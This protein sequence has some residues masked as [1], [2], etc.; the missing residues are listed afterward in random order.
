M[1]FGVIVV[2]IIFI[3]LIFY[4]TN[5]SNKS[6]QNQKTEP[7]RFTV[8]SLKEVAQNNQKKHHEKFEN[9]IEEAF[10]KHITQ[11]LKDTPNELKNTPVVT[12]LIMDSLTS[13][14]QNLID[15]LSAKSE[16][17]NAMSQ[18]K[19]ES[20]VDTAQKKVFREYFQYS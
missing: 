4:N 20:I 12:T 18:T 17:K 9:T 2:A 1:S 10:R 11:C 3:G 6:F 19:L 15:N 8:D 13:Y 16:I 14:A 5:R 7:R